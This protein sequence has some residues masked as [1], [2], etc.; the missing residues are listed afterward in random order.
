[1]TNNHIPICKYCG[2][3]MKVAGNYIDHAGTANEYHGTAFTC[4]CFLSKEI[5]TKTR[6]KHGHIEQ[7]GYD[8]ILYVDKEMVASFGTFEQAMDFMKK[9]YDLNTWS[10]DSE[11]SSG[12]HY[13]KTLSELEHENDTK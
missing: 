6:A 7:V 8:F 1:M 13:L 9:H 10:Y 12:F 5:T 3:N 2:E 11:N 4:D